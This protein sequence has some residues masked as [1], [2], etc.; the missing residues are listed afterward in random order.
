M[1]IKPTPMGLDQGTTT[2][3]AIELQTLGIQAGLIHRT[4]PVAQQAPL[5]T[6]VPLRN[7][8][9][10]PETAHSGADWA[11]G[12]VAWASSSEASACLLWRMNTSSG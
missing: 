2:P 10:I 5:V 1:A 4:I 3:F 9:S 12:L 8:R 6:A 7:A 11:D